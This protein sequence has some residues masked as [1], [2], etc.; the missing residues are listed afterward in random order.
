M[1][2]SDWSEFDSVN[3]ELWLHFHDCTLWIIWW[4]SPLPQ[5]SL[6]LSRSPPKPGSRGNPTT[7]V[8]EL[9]LR[10]LEKHIPTGINWDF[11]GKIFRGPWLF[12]LWVHSKEFYQFGEI[13]WPFRDLFFV[14]YR[15]E[16]R[17]CSPWR[18]NVSLTDVWHVLGGPQEDPKWMV[19][20][21]NRIR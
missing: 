21:R 10:F 16:V 12:L 2:D 8:L 17:V 6:Q 1:Q 15:T 13:I 3:E 14:M 20:N 9:L 18:V 19:R 7:N 5:M 11:R 4:G